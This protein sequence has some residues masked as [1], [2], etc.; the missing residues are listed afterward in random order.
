[1]IIH[2]LLCLELEFLLRLRD[3]RG[4][5]RE[6][7]DI[8]DQSELFLAQGLRRR[9]PVKLWFCSRQRR[10][11]GRVLARSSHRQGSNRSSL[12]GRCAVRDYAARNL[13]LRTCWAA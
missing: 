1:S 7:L 5:L 8:S 2:F 13:F 11:S 4:F 9:E 6:R 10:L 3:Q 12:D